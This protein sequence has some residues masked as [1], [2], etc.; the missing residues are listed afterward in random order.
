MRQFISI[1]GVLLFLLSAC[2][3]GERALLKQADAVMEEHPDSALGILQEIKREHISGKDLP[4]YALLMTQA[5]VKT[6]VPV[7]SDSLISIAYRKFG[8]DWWGDKG[9]RAN[10]YTGE[11]FFNQDKQRDAMK[12]YLTAYEESKRLGNDY[13]RAKSAERIADLFYNAYNYPEAAKYRKYA[14]EYYGKANRVTNQ[15]YAIAD[16]SA[17]YDNDGK[18]FLA[19]QILDSLLNECNKSLIKDNELISY[20]LKYR[21]Y[22]SENNVTDNNE[23]TYNSQLKNLSNR[24]KIEA[25]IFSCN[26]EP[27]DDSNTFRNDS[28]LKSI[29][30]LAISKEDSLHILYARYLNTVRHESE[31]P[32]IKMMDSL[33]YLQE[34]LSRDLLVESVNIAESEFYHEQSIEDRQRLKLYVV[35]F[36]VI[37]IISL[38]VS[39]TIWKTH[40]L[41]NIARSAEIEA[42]VEALVSLNAYVQKISAEKTALN[43]EIENK[44]NSLINL[45]NQLN[46]QRSKAKIL[47]QNT[48]DFKKQI[49]NLTKEHSEQSKKQ[50]IL[51]NELEHQIDNYK[52][53]INI[54]KNKFHDNDE[55]KSI[56]LEKLFKEKW[57]TLNMLCVEYF[58]KSSTQKLRDSFIRKIES[59]IKNIG[60]IDGLSQIEKEVDKYMDGIVGKMRNECP[61]IKA[62]DLTL[63]SLMCAGFSVKAMCL[64]LNIQSNNLYVKKNRLIKKIRET[65]SPN[66][67]KF[68]E[69]LK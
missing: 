29:E 50:T 2:S 54:L 45:I 7:D 5:Q 41:K 36:S 65:D 48:V 17:I 38:I 37:I 53:D 49:D 62:S 35:I 6:N 12:F 56:I 10:F 3:G 19:K 66:K 26:S 44:Q 46:F 30:K 69:R 21:E 64:I 18:T 28:V 24:K 43:L 40:R 4:Y 25:T 52:R 63:F 59:E 8:N 1:I 39:Y 47:E 13:W 67:D 16:L 20:I 34:S 55:R 57:T 32:I 60:S 9:I 51:L 33:L 11:V 42:S 31:T 68:L 14:I 23:R 27:E 61:S 15:R 58:E 22:L